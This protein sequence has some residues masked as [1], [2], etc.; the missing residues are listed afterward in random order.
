MLHITHV[1]I[2]YNYECLIIQIKI[3]L[4]HRTNTPWIFVHNPYAEKSSTSYMDLAKALQLW[5]ELQKSHQVTITAEQ[6]KGILFVTD[7]SYC[8]Y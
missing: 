1:I 8:M 5:S 4:S 2:Y 7:D 6:V 3:S